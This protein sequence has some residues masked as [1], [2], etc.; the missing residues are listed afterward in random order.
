[1]TPQQ[2]LSQAHRLDMYITSN[3]AELERIRSEC[4]NISSPSLEPH[5]NASRNIKAP[6]DGKVEKA[7]V[8]EQ[9]IREQVNHL[10]ELK[11]QIRQTINSLSSMDERMVLRYHYLE[12]LPWEEVAMKMHTGR[13]TVRRWHN[14]ALHNIKMPKLP[15]IL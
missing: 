4:N 15:M 6:F 10:L 9:E 7:M 14:R 13:S 12:S 1:M 2:Y 3:L 8:L 5:Y 11:T